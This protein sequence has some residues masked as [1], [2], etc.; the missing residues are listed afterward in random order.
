MTSVAV[1]P[2]G[3]VFVA[4]FYNDRIQKFTADGEF[5]TAFGI[6]SEGPGQTEVAVA[7]DADGIVWT[8]NFANNRVEKWQPAKN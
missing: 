6:P 5:L 1:G 4:D 3:S 7:V 8:A 2:D